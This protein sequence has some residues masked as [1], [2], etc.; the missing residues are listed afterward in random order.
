MFWELAEGDFEGKL[1]VSLYGQRKQLMAKIEEI[2]EEHKK[3]MEE[4]DKLKDKLSDDKDPEQNVKDKLTVDVDENTEPSGDT[5][6]IL[7]QSD[8]AMMPLVR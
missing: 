4:K 1:E 8:R 2:K 5:C 3:A 7:E 6:E